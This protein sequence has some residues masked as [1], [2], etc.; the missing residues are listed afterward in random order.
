[1]PFHNLEFDGVAFLQA[2]IA[3][4][5]NGSVVHKNI[6]TILA[7]VFLWAEPIS[8]FEEVLVLNCLTGWCLLAQTEGDML[9]G[10]LWQIGGIACSTAYLNCAPS[11]TGCQQSIHAISI[12][13]DGLRGKS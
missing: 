8:T 1:L 12:D 9:P 10:Q 2:L 7:A 13:S 11:Y 4:A 6:G 3:V 5:A